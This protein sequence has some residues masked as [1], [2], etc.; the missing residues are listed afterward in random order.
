MVLYMHAVKSMKSKELERRTQISI[1]SVLKDYH[2]HLHRQRKFNL[3]NKKCISRYRE[4]LRLL[5]LDGLQHF[6]GAGLEGPGFWTLLDSTQAGEHARWLGIVLPW[7]QVDR[8]RGAGGG[9]LRMVKGRI[10]AWGDPERILWL[11]QWRSS[12]LQLSHYK[13]MDG[14]KKPSL[15]L[16]R[17]YFWGNKETLCNSPTLRT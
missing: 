14:R 15:C 6:W 10:W 11:Q 12:L 3:D 7:R 13:Q 1:F 8:D 17:C 16:Q 5:A 2:T 9:R 4:H